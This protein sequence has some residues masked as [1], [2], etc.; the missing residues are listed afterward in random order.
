[1]NGN[2]M[3]CLTGIIASAV[4]WV[5]TLAVASDW[6]N[7]RGPN[8]DGVSTEKGWLTDW[9]KEGLKQLWAVDLGPSYGSVAVSD[10]K[11]YAMWSITNK[12]E[13]IYCLDAETGKEVWNHPF[14]KMPGDSWPGP[15]STPAVDGTFVYVA[16]MNGQ[17]CCLDADAGL[18]VWNK[19]MKTDFNLA[20]P[21]HLF[22]SSPIT[23]GDL[24]LVNMGPAGVA[25]DK[26][27]GHIVWNNVVPHSHSAY[28]APV[29]CTVETQPCVAF[30]GDAALTVVKETSGQ[31][32]SICR[33]GAGEKSPDPLV[34]GNHLF[35]T[36]S[37]G[38]AFVTVD[39]PTST[40]ARKSGPGLQ[41]RFSTPV[42]VGD[43]VYG[44][45]GSP[46]DSWVKSKKGF[47]LV[48]VDP[49]DG[50]VKW[51]QEGI[52]DGGLIAADGK[53]IVLDRTGTLIL[54][55][56]SPAAYKELARVQALPE[57]NKEGTRGL[58][59]AYRKGACFAMPVLCNGRIYVRNNSGTLACLDVRGR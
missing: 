46:D 23:H 26:K 29:P 20:M 9:P 52:V 54:V 58:H 38:C 49:R 45:N 17:V 31:A 44:F 14:P 16:T 30:L 8:H 5:A 2:R 28:A 22:S 43:C 40:V 47:G 6:P 18:V 7:Y 51:A 36:T 55:E 1:M 37:G 33:M 19:D 57:P 11:L 15:R 34:I 12:D 50:T 32:V 21:H 13:V 53:L 25:F 3:L 39:A 41:S 48:C 24:L 59:A 10:G 27:S 4:V 56:A 35:Q 42:L